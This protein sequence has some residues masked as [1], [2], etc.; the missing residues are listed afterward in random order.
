[1][2][3]IDSNLVCRE[4]LDRAELKRF[5]SF[6]RNAK[7]LYHHS[8][9]EAVD[10]IVSDRLIWLTPIEKQSTEEKYALYCEGV[11]YIACF[12][13]K[14]FTKGM[15]RAKRFKGEKGVAT[16]N[17]CVKIRCESLDELID[18]SVCCVMIDEQNHGHNLS[19]VGKNSKS[20]DGFADDLKGEIFVKLNFINPEYSKDYQNISDLDINDDEK[21]VVENRACKKVPQRFDYQQEV[22]IAAEL[23]ATHKVEINKPIRLICYFSQKVKLKKIDI[24]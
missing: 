2:V 19:Y 5:K 4:I 11:F 6:V 17:E 8:D 13:K 14:Q 23:C 1:M 18:K 9:K 3:E 16:I 22:R 21:M 24:K 7:V 10:S 15:I 20:I 12:G